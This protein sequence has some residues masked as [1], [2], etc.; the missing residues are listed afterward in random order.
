MSIQETLRL[1][2]LIGE[3]ELEGGECII[4][5]SEQGKV[6]LVLDDGLGSTC[7]Y[8]FSAVLNDV[9]QPYAVIHCTRGVAQTALRGCNVSIICYVSFDYMGKG[10]DM[11]VLTGGLRTSLREGYTSRLFA[12]LTR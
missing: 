8:K 10:F 6:Q 9:P 11:G 4:A 1:R 2:P 7:D 5:D 3:K 12:V